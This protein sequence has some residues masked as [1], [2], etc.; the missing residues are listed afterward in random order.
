MESTYVFIY[1]FNI[2]IIIKFFVFV[3]YLYNYFLSWTKKDLQLQLL[4]ATI[5]A[6]VLGHQ[7]VE[8]EGDAI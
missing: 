8:L 4:R 5:F 3:N 6:R 2:I 7:N 1:L